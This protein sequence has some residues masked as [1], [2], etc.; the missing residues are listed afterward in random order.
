M[1]GLGGLLLGLVVVLL[2]RSTALS[3]FAAR[4]LVIDVLVFAVV[5]D[6]LRNGPARGSTFGF[7]LGIA[8]DL[9]AAHWLGRHA[10]ALT[11]I[12][13]V[14]GRL[15]STLVRD[16]PRTQMVLLL[17]ATGVHQFWSAAFELSDRAAWPYVLFRTLIGTA[18]TAVLGTL[19][20]GI[21]RR[22]LGGWLFHHAPTAGDTLR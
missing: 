19:L 18:V 21:G 10:L 3:A 20:L 22:L 13:Y 16:S 5:V 1:R 4:G 2:L 17:V 11:L 12:G 7:L 8:A 6:A 15:S 9:D 14:V